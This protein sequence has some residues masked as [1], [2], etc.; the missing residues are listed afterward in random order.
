M[1]GLEKITVGAALIS[2]PTINL[3]STSVIQNQF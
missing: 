2:P 1:Q 3:K